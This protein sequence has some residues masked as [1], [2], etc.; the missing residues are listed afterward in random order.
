MKIRFGLL[1]LA[2]VIGIGY[3]IFSF[4]GLKDSIEK[5]FMSPADLTFKLLFGNTGSGTKWW[6]PFWDKY[7]N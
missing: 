3:A 7:L 4:T 1:V 6:T 5:I 2:I